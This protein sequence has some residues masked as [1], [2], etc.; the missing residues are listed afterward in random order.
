MKA[1]GAHTS[2]NV[3]GGKCRPQRA[4]AKSTSEV[5]SV[6]TLMPSICLTQNG[7]AAGETVPTKPKASKISGDR[8]KHR[9]WRLS[10]HAS[11]WA[12]GFSESHLLY[13]G[14]WQWM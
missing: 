10:A 2:R 3:L 14:V 11:G 1:V 9:G 4:H 5:L 6:K 13:L 7:A 8:R 12:A